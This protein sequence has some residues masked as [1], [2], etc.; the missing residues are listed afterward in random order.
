[1]I[2]G[3]LYLF[4]LACV[5]FLVFCAGLLPWPVRQR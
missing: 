4:F 3:F 1:M 5:A 2:R